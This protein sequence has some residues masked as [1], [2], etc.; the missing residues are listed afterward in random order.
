MIVYHFVDPD[1]E[2]K[3]RIQQNKETLILEFEVPAAH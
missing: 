3:K 1:L 2:L